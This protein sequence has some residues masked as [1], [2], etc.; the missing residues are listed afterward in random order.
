MIG[1]L[2]VQGPI[3]SFCFCQISLD[4]LSQSRCQW[5]LSKGAIPRKTRTWGF[6]KLIAQKFNFQHEIKNNR[7]YWRAGVGFG[8]SE[9][10][11]AVQEKA[12]PSLPERLEVANRSDR[13]VFLSRPFRGLRWTSTWFR[14]RRCSTQPSSAC[15]SSFGF[16]RGLRSR[17]KIRALSNHPQFKPLGL[18]RQRSTLH[19]L[20]YTI[21]R[22]KLEFD[23]LPRTRRENNVK[24]YRERTHRIRSLWQVG[25]WKL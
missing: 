6:H 13:I 16:N 15:G 25:L 12:M 10:L 17:E 22:W 20:L 24:C 23:E 21:Q 2:A 7:L 19:R 14:W 5:T 3:G 8:I 4:C 1:T 18:D 11:S 9:D